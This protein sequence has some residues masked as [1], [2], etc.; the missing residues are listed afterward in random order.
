MVQPAKAESVLETGQQTHGMVLT[1]KVRWT[2]ALA[3]FCLLEFAIKPRSQRLPWREVALVLIGALIREGAH[4]S[5]QRSHPGNAGASLL[6]SLI[7]DR[8]LRPLPRVL[9]GNLGWRERQKTRIR[10]R[11]KSACI[12]GCLRTAA[13]LMSCYLTERS[14][15]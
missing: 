2:E 3:G 8:S 15:R 5:R 4:S 10:A 7:N 6:S 9:G 12:P 14:R 11:R 1:P 13:P